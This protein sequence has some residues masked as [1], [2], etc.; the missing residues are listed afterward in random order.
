MRLGIPALAR[1][2]KEC[3]PLIAPGSVPTGIVHLGLGAFHRAHQAVYTEEAIA[4]AGGDW[5]IAAVAPRSVTVIEKVV[6]FT[7]AAR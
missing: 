3:R 1:V 7:T 6:P 4:A 5:G 2:P